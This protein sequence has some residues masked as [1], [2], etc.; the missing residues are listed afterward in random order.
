MRTDQAASVAVVRHPLVMGPRLRGMAPSCYSFGAARSQLS[1]NTVCAMKCSYQP[2]S[3]LPVHAHDYPQLTMVL[4]GGYWE[5]RAGTTM[6]CEEGAVL[7][8]PAGDSHSNRFSTEEAVCLS[9]SRSSGPPCTCTRGPTVH[10]CCE[11]H[12]GIEGR[13]LD[14]SPTRL[15]M[16]LALAFDVTATPSSDVL[17][18]RLQRPPIVGQGI[19]H[20]CWNSLGRPSCKSARLAPID[21]H[22]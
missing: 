10:V 19:H 15:T 7:F 17:D 6:A 5:Q 14:A 4:R 18:Q 16:W 12:Q 13:E 11:A 21:S 2:E 20:W 9:L 22:G 8:R 1:T 3:A